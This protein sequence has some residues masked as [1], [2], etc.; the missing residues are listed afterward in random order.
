M[1][2]SKIVAGVATNLDNWLFKDLRIGQ[3]WSP[4]GF[5]TL[6]CPSQVKSTGEKGV[7]GSY[8]F[9]ACVLSVW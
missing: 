5:L 2:A 4:N 7:G 3:S 8:P 9:V 6:V 1:P